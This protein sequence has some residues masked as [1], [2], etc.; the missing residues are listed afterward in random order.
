MSDLKIEYRETGMLR[1]DGRNARKHARK[2]IQKIADS[3]REF[4]FINPVLIDAEDKIIAG[5]GRVSAAGFL[6]MQKVPTVR[7]DHLSPE[8]LRAYVI[9][10][11]KLAELAE[12]DPDLLAIEFQYLSE[13]EVDFD[14]E[15]TGFE[16]A[17]IDFLIED[18]GPA[19]GP[20][21]ADD[22]PVS[23]G[24][25]AIITQPG[26]LWI[27]GPHQMLCGD[28]KEDG[29]FDRL[30]EGEK[31]Q[32]VFVTP[33]TMDALGEVFHHLAAHSLDGSIHFVCAD[34][35]D[36]RGLLEA[37]TA[38]YD[39]LADFCVWNKSKARRARM[40]QS[41]LELIFVFRNGKGSHINNISRGRHG[42]RASNVWD[43]PAAHTSRANRST[44]PTCR[45]TEKPVALVADA[46]LDCSK[47]RGI[48]L[49]CFAATGTTII[50]ADK[51]GRRAYAMERDPRSV[52]AAIRRW[53][54]H[55]GRHAVHA[56]TGEPFAAM[57]AL[58][59]D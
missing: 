24:G 21:V 4:G 27:L 54:R 18:N 42:R 13:L 8:Q 16:T 29:S 47:R 38:V 35:S 53:Q 23:E 33:S 59:A 11:N 9:A 44:K 3:I 26:D 57:E 50:A 19:H 41:K 20:D 28:P 30:M 49:D 32:M 56:E 22:V 15:I 6:G 34:W 12:W 58:R 5:H 1:A 25:G 45:P 2:Q 31:A 14:V 51:T 39:D 48:V 36:M 10:D 40:Y 17:E 43:Y 37:G 52:D 46:I 55:T 7:L